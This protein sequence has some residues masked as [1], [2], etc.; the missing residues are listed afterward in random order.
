[1]KKIYI[2][3]CI[4]VLV[5]LAIVLVY[6]R[7][8]QTLPI[9]ETQV[10][11]SAFDAKNSRFNVDGT[12]VTLV[13]GRA[14]TTAA[15]GSASKEVTTYFGN[16]AKGDVNGDGLEDAVFLVTRASG[17]SG[18]FY[19]A[20]AVLATST[21][22]KTTNAFFVGDRISPQ[23]TEIRNGEIYVNYA[24]RKAGEP[25]TSLPSQGATLMLKV[26]PDGVLEGLMK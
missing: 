6:F 21:G 13:D 20:V 1:M 5:G 22:Y 2:T 4:V 24:E 11:Q 25:M 26:T 16:E 8:D 3:L 17:G 23:T 12:L 10:K 7:K 18:L 9:V 19:F 14:E 15:P